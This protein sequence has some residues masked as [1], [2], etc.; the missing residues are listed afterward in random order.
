MYFEQIMKLHYAALFTSCSKQAAIVQ[1][2]SYLAKRCT[3][4]TFTY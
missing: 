1:E 4:Q 3:S 2:F